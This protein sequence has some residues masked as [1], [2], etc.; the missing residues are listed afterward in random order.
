MNRRKQSTSSSCTVT[1]VG[2]A[3]TFAKEFFNLGGS[4][5]WMLVADA[6]ARDVAGEFGQAQADGETFFAGH[7]AIQ[8]DLLLERLLGVHGVNA[9]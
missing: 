3:E 2:E 6:F 9:T 5:V 4:G 1:A 7:L 8:L